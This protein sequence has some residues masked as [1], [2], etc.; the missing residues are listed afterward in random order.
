MLYLR[1]GMGYGE[2]V[3]VTAQCTT[4]TGMQELQPMN[5]S[6][7]D[8][9]DRTWASRSSG[10]YIYF[11]LSLNDVLSLLYLKCTWAKYHIEH[12]YTL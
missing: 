4:I 2:Q 8:I 12:T 6:K 11:I 1:L 9:P 10:V 3:S 5:E 7:G